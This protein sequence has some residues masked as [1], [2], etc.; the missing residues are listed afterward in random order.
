MKILE[1]CRT[2]IVLSLQ[3]SS[4]RLLALWFLF[5]PIN[6]HNV[7]YNSSYYLLHQ[8]YIENNKHFTVF[9]LISLMYVAWIC[10]A[11]LIFESIERLWNK[12]YLEIRPHGQSQWRN[13][14]SNQSDLKKISSTK[15][16]TESLWYKNSWEHL[17]HLWLQNFQAPCTASCCSETLL[18]LGKIL[19]YE[20]YMLPAVRMRV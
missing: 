15:D 4:F 17:D 6:Q 16:F 2:L 10:N 8:N 12:I 1:P 7:W 14:I 9:P 11:E 19:N 13:D 5:F 20:L 3:S 18:P